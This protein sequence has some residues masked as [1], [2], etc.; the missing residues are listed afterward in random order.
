MAPR[1][2]AERK[3]DTL[4]RLEG[5]ENAWVATAGQGVPHLVPLSVWWDGEILTMTTAATSPTARNAQASG[6]ARVAFGDTLDVVVIDAAVETVAVPDAPER[7]SSGFV[8]RCGWD[9]AANDGDW[10]YLLLTPRRVQAWRDADEIDGRTLMRDGRW[11][12]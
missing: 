1:T 11:L 3:T 7:I 6:Q 9:P 2:I 4:A 8:G 5:D 10:V 12:D